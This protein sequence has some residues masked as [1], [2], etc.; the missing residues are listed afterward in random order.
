MSPVK[1][2]VW[3]EN[4]VVQVERVRS[5][6]STSYLCFKNIMCDK[7]GSPS[8]PSPTSRRDM[9]EEATK[10]VFAVQFGMDYEWSKTEICRQETVRIDL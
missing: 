6:V 2:L 8:I 7:N 4:V 10:R 5:G 3:Q 9:M 1:T